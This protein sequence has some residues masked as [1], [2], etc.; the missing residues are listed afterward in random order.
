S[1]DHYT[2]STAGVCNMQKTPKTL[3]LI[4]SVTAALSGCFD[5]SDSE[6]GTKNNPD[7]GSSVQMEKR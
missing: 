4:L 3:F 5:N 1:L 7:N 2:L 6:Q